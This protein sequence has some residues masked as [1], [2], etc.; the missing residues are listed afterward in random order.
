[1]DKNLKYDKIRQNDDSNNRE[2]V[3]SCNTPSLP[4]THG[5]AEHWVHA[6]LQKHYSRVKISEQVH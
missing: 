4:T 6:K 1:M 2:H 3:T 5:C